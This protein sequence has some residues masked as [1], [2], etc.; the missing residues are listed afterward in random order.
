MKFVA[1]SDLHGQLELL[2][3]IQELALNHEAKFILSVGDHTVFGMEEKKILKKINALPAPVFLIHGNHESANVTAKLC[4]DLNN[5]TFLHKNIQ[6]VQ[7]FTLIGYGGGGF[8][9]TDSEFSE[10]IKT[11]QE[12]KNIIVL[13]HQP[14]FGTEID[15]VGHHTG[16]ED[17]REFIEK[18]QPLMT[19]SGHIHETFGLYEYVGRTLVINPGPLGVVLE[20][21]ENALE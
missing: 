2:D 11:A 16:L 3:H 21:D 5:V 8:A 6:K 13:T 1:F 7:S 9:Q 14:P 12:K 19:L 4:K 15:F 10:F 17:L 20:I 18:H